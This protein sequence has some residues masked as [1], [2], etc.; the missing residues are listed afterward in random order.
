MFPETWGS[1]LSEIKL[2]LKGDDNSTPIIK[3]TVACVFYNVSV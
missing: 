3:D 2:N 1:K